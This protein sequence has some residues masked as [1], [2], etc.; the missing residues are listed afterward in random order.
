MW[1]TKNLLLNYQRCQRRAFLDVQGDLEQRD[2][3]GDYTQ[4]AVTSRR[5]ITKQGLFE[6]NTLELNHDRVEGL[7]LSSRLLT[8]RLSSDA[9]QWKPSAAVNSRPISS[10]CHSSRPIG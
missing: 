3:P 4:F 1:L 9:R 7:S 2:P 6:R 5:I 8:G 10:I